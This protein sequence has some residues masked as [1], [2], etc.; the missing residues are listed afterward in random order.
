[1]RENTLSDK[2][3]MELMTIVPE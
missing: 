1:M 3:A 2:R